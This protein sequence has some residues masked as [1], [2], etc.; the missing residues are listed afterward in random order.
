MTAGLLGAACRQFERA[1]DAAGGQVVFRLAI[2]GKMVELRFAGPTLVDAVVPALSHLEAG[3]G[4][5]PALTVLLW[6]T[7]GTGVPFPVPTAEERLRLAAWRRRG[8]WEEVGT[9]GERVMHQPY[10]DVLGILGDGLAVHWVAD[11][12]SLPYYERS[13]PMLH[14]LHWWLAGHGLQMVHAAAVGR[15][16]G[17]VLIVGPGGTGKSTTALAC[18]GSP[19]PYASEDYTLVS[20]GPAPRAVGLYRSAKLERGHELIESLRLPRIDNPEPVPGDKALYFIDDRI[21]E[22]F[23]L[24]ALVVPKVAGGTRPR[25]TRLPSGAEVLSALAPSSVLQLPGTGATA[26]AVM[27]EV[28][29]RVPSYLLELGADIDAIPAVLDGLL[30]T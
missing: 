5:P 7:A 13:A 3:E 16:E 27:R 15:P 18:L 25:L 9:G 10:E 6:D 26:L 14:L 24:R 20:A 12:K 17:G 22:A 30:S 4:R 23:L 28:C 21:V 1:L 29:E 2:D 8:P 19:V 11:A